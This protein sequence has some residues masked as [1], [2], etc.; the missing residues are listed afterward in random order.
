MTL[1]IDE[2]FGNKEVVQPFRINRSLQLAHV[3]PWAIKWGSPSGGNLVTEFYQGADLLKLI[4]TPIA[5][6]VDAVDGTYGHGPLR[7][8]TSPLRLN[9]NRKNA[10]TEYTI[11]WYISGST[12]D[13]SNFIGLIRRYEAKFYPTYGDDLVSGDAPNSMVQP[14]G[15]ELFELTY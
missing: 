10:F 13:A 4:N 11:K 8:D 9:H 3:R 7:I 6:I 14:F 5:D 12:Q 15:F 1:I 2:L